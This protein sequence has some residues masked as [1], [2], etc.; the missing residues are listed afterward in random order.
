MSSKQNAAAGNTIEAT[1]QTFIGIAERHG[2]KWEWDSDAPVEL[3]CW[4]P[5]QDGLDFEL[6]LNLQNED[7][8]GVQTDIFTAEWFPANDPS[9]CSAFINFVDGLI[10]GDVK[11]RCFFGKDP[12]V[13]YRVDAERIIDGNRRTVFRYR[14]G[15]RL[16]P[17][18]IRYVFNGQARADS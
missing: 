18:A 2:L 4:L 1:R 16:R 14:R 10:A 11:F 3:A 5:A 15:W 17:M 9:K 8:I 12:E 6:W 13:P 7:E